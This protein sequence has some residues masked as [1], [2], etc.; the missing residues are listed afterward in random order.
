MNERRR[1][2]DW[3]GRSVGLA[4]FAAGITMLVVVFVRAV[5]LGSA[6]PREGQRLEFWAIQFGVQVVVLFVAGMVASWIAGRGAQLY[7][8]SGRP[9]V[10]D[11]V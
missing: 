2:P 8:A 5:A 9:P 11:D 10:I 7:A 3:L 4:V 1:R 6:G